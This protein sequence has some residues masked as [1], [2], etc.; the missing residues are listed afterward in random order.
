MSRARLVIT[1]VVLEGRSVREV[2]AA[3]G[4]SRSWIHELV[5]RY[6]VEGEAAFEPRSRRPLTRPDATPDSTVQLV[7]AIRQQLTTKGFD[8]GP[9]TIVWH[10]E[11]HHHITL[12]R[13]TAYRILRRA[14]TI[15][16]EPRKKPRSSYIRFQAEQPNETWQADFT[17]WQ[18]ANG[19]DIE[20]LCWIDDHSR[21][22]LSVTAHLR[23][24]G[25]IVRDTF[26]AIIATHGAP[27]STLTDNG[28]VFT[29]R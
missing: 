2:A 21:F 3:Y 7:L 29:T 22:A 1:A 16:P 23:V 8:A 20:I 14:N 28:M 11:Q 6:G 25:L 24:T 10:L 18:L 26:R 15:T 5:A 17:H 9:D 13:A 12:S 4:V 19:T 27:L